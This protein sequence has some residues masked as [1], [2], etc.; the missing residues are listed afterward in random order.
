MLARL[1]K[2]SKE[3]EG[4]FTLIELLVVMIII[5]ILAAIAIP[6][7]LSQRKKAQDA[8]A[9]ADISKIGKEVATYYVDGTG[10]TADALA[11]TNASGRYLLNVAAVGTE[12]AIVN[13]D[14]GKISANNV[15][16]NQFY[17][18]D[19]AWCVSVKNARRQGRRGLQVLRIGRSWH[20]CVHDVRRLIRSRQCRGV[21]RTGR[22]PA[23]PP[24]GSR[25]ALKTGSLVT[26]SDY[27][28]SATQGLEAGTC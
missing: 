26:I 12:A 23:F 13:L 19:K 15:L 14:L 20:R 16:F 27:H 28:Y 3:N 25:P 21:V 1:R 22:P 8:S 17:T 7:F 5:G 10:S 4:G 9:K 24:F 6:I 11:I 2:S 18:D